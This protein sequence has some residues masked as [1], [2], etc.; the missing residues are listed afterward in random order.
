MKDLKALGIAVGQ[1][2]TAT[3][4]EKAT[5][6]KLPAGILTELWKGRTLNK[7][8]MAAIGAANKTTPKAKPAK[9]GKQ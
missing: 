5:E 7:K 8:A 4:I 9:E 3:L 2:V 6:A 1:T